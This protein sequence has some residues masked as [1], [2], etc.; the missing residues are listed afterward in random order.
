MKRRD[1]IRHG[2]VLLASAAAAQLPP[3]WRAWA[4][5]SA[6]DWSRHPTPEISPNEDFY[7][8]SKGFFHPRLKL[9]GW[10]LQVG[11]LVKN[12]KTFDLQSLAALDRHKEVIG[13]EC[14]GNR[15][16]GDALDCAV[17]RGTRF[18]RLIEAVE[19]R[20]SAVDVVLYGADGYADSVPLSWFRTNFALLASTMNGEPLPRSH[21]FPLRLLTPG[22]YGMKNV[23]WIER[24][25][26]VDADY[27]GYWQVRGWSDEAWVKPHARIDAPI[28][29]AELPRGPTLIAGVAFTGN[30]GVSKVELSFD[31]G[32]TWLP[33]RLK[34]PRSPYSW[35]LWAYPWQAPA[36]LQTITARCVDGRGRIQ[37]KGPKGQAPDHAEGW[38]TIRVEVT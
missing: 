37:P 22:I 4:A 36:G 11:G 12:P 35:V 31:R 7:V 15:I 17:W 13:L 28:G 9:G 20:S 24:V 10:S 14:V 30:Q 32:R 2:A 38:H 16:G 5:E 34:A 18:G 21:G 6:L 8:T 19:P 33:A 27:Q 25:E 23:K 1:F 3:V 29:G 26:F